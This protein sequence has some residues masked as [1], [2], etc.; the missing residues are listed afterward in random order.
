MPSDIKGQTIRAMKAMQMRQSRAIT[1][2]LSRHYSFIIDWRGWGGGGGAVEGQE[3]Q[4]M[5]K[6]SRRTRVIIQ[7]VIGRI[8]LISFF[9]IPPS[10]HVLSVSVRATTL[11]LSLLPSAPSPTSLSLSLSLSPQSGISTNNLSPCPLFPTSLRL[12]VSVTVSLS[13]SLSL[14]LFV[15]LFV[16]LCVFVVVFA[17][18]QD[19]KQYCTYSIT[20]VNKKN[21]SFVCSLSLSLSLS[22]PL[23]PPS[24]SPLSLS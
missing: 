6:C 20:L 11:S 19:V 8:G 9:P 22:L 16:C 1:K 2:T 7:I 14:S 15:C 13:S 21:R 5:V 10:P 3:K 12:C 17:R 24:L 18:G 4:Q 23:P